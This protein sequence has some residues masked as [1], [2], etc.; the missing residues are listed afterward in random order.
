MSKRL[1]YTEKGKGLAA[2]P[3][4]PRATRIRI[5]AVDNSE[6]IKK[7]AL[8]LVGRVTNPKIQK[9]WSL[10]P[11]FTEHWKVEVT[12]VGAELGQGCFQFQFA[13][14]RDLLKVLENRPYHFARWMIILQRWEISSAPTFPNLIPFWIQVQGIPLHL[15]S[16]VALTSLAD[17]IG[18]RESVEI[19]ATKARVRVLINGLKP[20]IK[21]AT[22]D[23]DSGE[24]A[25]VTLV[26]EKLEKH[27][28][29][30]GMLDHEIQDCPLA[31]DN[32]PHASDPEKRSERFPHSH[33]ENRHKPN[34]PTSRTHNN[35]Q[36]NQ[37]TQS[38]GEYHFDHHTRDAERRYARQHPS[39]PAEHGKRSPIRG[40]NPPVLPYSRS[41]R[42]NYYS[43]RVLDLATSDHSR[44]YRRPDPSRSNR[45][46]SLS[47]HK[48]GPSRPV[49]IEKPTNSRND[50]EENQR[51]IEGTESSLPPRNPLQ[52]EVPNEALT[53]AISEVREAMSRYTNCPDPNESAAR[54]E[55]L[56][57]AEESGEVEETA[58]NM[59]KEYQRPMVPESEF[60]TV[61]LSP[62]HT[63]PRVPAMMRL[64]PILEDEEE[65]MIPLSVPPAA[66]TKRKPGRP[67]GRRNIAA[68]PLSFLGAGVR[69]RKI[70]KTQPSPSR[71]K[72]PSSAS[73]SDATSRGK[74][75]RAGTAVT[76]RRRT[77]KPPIPSLSAAHRRQGADFQNPSSPLP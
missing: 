32:T 74:T 1:S 58:A 46:H 13:S 71:K 47:T 69:K 64:G 27:C 68:S 65:P 72:T 51:H 12:P 8:T 48:S 20:L 7:H 25:M 59:I 57:H 38:R 21:T 4:P 33:L 76:L 61:N 10:I 52:F 55:W 15:W 45:S 23:F 29:S 14:E 24:E 41:D 62:D 31:V 43:P 60:I 6:L 53:E 44:E 28:T 3:E 66:A 42:S 63:P 2:P 75:V 34:H 54:K 9:L 37:R 39:H 5:P 22:L 67:P 77:V 50:R 36:S 40:S 11:F 16:E 70:T 35:S 73:L 26:Y 56:R 49:W 18:I 30:C 19:T 17:N